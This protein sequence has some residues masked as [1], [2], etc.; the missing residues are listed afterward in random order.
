V[1]PSDT[2]TLFAFAPAR[3]LSFA[4]G[5]TALTAVFVGALWLQWFLGFPWFFRIVT[6]VVDLLL[7]HVVIDLWLGA[8]VVIAGNGTLRVRHAVLGAG[9]SRTLRAAD[10]ASIDLHINMQTQGRFGT[11][12]YE[13]RARLKNRRV[14]SLGDGIRNKRHAEWLA[15]Q[16]RASIGLK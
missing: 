13:V 7:V 15:A 3:N 1:E 10:I 6:G 9:R 2:G 16:M 14:A 4:T 11:P 12:Y 5:V 8:T